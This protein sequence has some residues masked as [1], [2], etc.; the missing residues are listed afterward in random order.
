MADSFLSTNN[1]THNNN[2]IYQYCIL[3]GGNAPE[4]DDLDNELRR[5]GIKAHYRQLR[6]GGRLYR[7]SSEDVPLLP[8]DG[9]PYLGDDQSG[10]S[11]YPL[12]NEGIQS[13]GPEGDWV[14]IL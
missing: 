8:D 1:N 10:H 5:R 11:I 12:D 2:M 4:F 13:L 6:A 7:I 14:A 3:P 9:G